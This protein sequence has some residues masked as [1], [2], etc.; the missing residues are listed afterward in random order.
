MRVSP[1]SFWCCKKKCSSPFGLSKK[2]VEWSILKIVRLTQGVPGSCAT[3][4]PLHRRGSLWTL[5]TSTAWNR[6]VYMIGC[7]EASAISPPR[8]GTRQLRVLVT[9]SLSLS[10]TVCVQRITSYV[11]FCRNAQRCGEMETGMSAWAFHPGYRV[12]VCKLKKLVHFV[13]PIPRYL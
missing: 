3:T 12:Q 8:N 4:D 2:W 9:I 13:L 5:L 1:D 6:N 7:A 11:L 10:G